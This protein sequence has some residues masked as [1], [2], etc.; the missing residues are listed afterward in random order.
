M[1]KADVL[2]MLIEVLEDTAGPEGWSY[3]SI[4]AHEF[5]LALVKRLELEREGDL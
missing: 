2:R 4:P 1:G 3:E 5:Y